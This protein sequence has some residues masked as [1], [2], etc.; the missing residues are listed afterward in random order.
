MS[1]SIDTGIRDAEGGK[2]KAKADPPARR[3]SA[4]AKRLAARFALPR[5]KKATISWPLRAL[6]FAPVLPKGRTLLVPSFSSVSRPLGA[7]FEYVVRGQLQRINP[8]AIPDH[9]LAEEALDAVSRHLREC[10]YLDIESEYT[11]EGMS[12]KPERF[13]VPAKAPEKLLAQLRKML[14][15]T[16]ALHAQ[17]IADGVLGTELLE[18]YIKLARWHG[19][20]VKWGTFSVPHDW[21]NA[22]PQAVHELRSMYDLVKWEQFKAKRRC[23]LRPRFPLSSQHGQNEPD[24]VIDDLIVDLK[25]TASATLQRGDV[26][27]V[28]RYFAHSEIE[29]FSRRRKGGITKL[30]LYYAR[31][32]DSVLI[33]LANDYPREK[34]EK[35]LAWYRQKCMPQ[36]VNGL[37]RF[38]T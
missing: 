28:L 24:L 12:G 7:A 32:G 31:F 21:N 8:R 26:D 30:Q 9:W 3:T 23:L 2:Q 19:G 29:G 14:H 25:T 18:N 22:D 33:D 4:L 16:K 35:Y 15:R 10:G 34:V 13:S 11:V 17:F 1:E 6:R 36:I 20:Y 37:G 38:D 27:Q 5:R